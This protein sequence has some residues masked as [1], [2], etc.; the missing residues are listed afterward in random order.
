VIKF[1]HDGLHLSCRKTC[2]R[3]YDGAYVSK[4]NLEV[5]PFVVQWVVQN[6]EEMCELGAIKDRMSPWGVV[7]KGKALLLTRVKAL[8]RKECWV[9]TNLTTMIVVVGGCLWIVGLPQ[10]RL[11]S[12]KI[13]LKCANPLR[14]LI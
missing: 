2:C 9:T 6:E 7:G 3:R 14:P 8:K 11:S 4:C 12:L 13:R 5:E 1:K 10:S